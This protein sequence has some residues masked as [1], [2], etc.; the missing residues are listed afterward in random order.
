MKRALMIFVPAITTIIILTMFINKWIPVEASGKY[1]DLGLP[2][3][4]LNYLLKMCEIDGVDSDLACAIL[5][6]ETHGQFVYG[7]WDDEVGNFRSVGYFQ[8]RDCNWD[9]MMDQYTVDVF[10]HKGNIEAGVT[11]LWELT[12][13]YPN[14]LKMV[15]TSYKAGESRAKLLLDDGITLGC[16]EEVQEYITEY[17]GK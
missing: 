8:I 15:I 7:D 12:Q 3:D 5:K 14:D 6:S 2:Q 16:V 9:R 13:K 10:T 1:S 11:M 17:R 4:E